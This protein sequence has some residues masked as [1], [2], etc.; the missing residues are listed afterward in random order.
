MKPSPP[1]ILKNRSTLRPSY[2]SALRTP[3]YPHPPSQTLT[4]MAIGAIVQGFTDVADVLIH[5]I[6]VIVSD[7]AKPIHCARCKREFV[8]GFGVTRGLASKMGGA[9]FGALTDERP[10]SAYTLSDAQI[11]CR[12]CYE[13]YL[14]YVNDM[15]GKIDNQDLLPIEMFFEERDL[16]DPLLAEKE[17]QAAKENPGSPGPLIIVART[18]SRN[19]DS[20]KS[21]ATLS[22]SSSR[23][24]S[25]SDEKERSFAKGYSGDRSKKSS[26]APVSFIGQGIVAASAGT[27]LVATTST[28]PNSIPSQYSTPPSQELPNLP[29][30]GAGRRSPSPSFSSS[31][32][33]LFRHQSRSHSRPSSPAPATSTP[34]SRRFPLS[35]G[36]L[37]RLFFASFQPN[38][39]HI[40]AAVIQA[41]RVDFHVAIFNEE[42]PSIASDDG[43]SLMSGTTVRGEAEPDER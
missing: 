17:K 35:V 42:T 39:P 21:T 1:H 32:A 14:D 25:I 36:A 7:P 11:W 23:R 28:T 18:P 40:A 4:L 2:S 5:A 31:V 12:M 13:P 26:M 8:D 33:S 43:A 30:L 24:S 37:R 22:R 34:P 3:K 38:H 6:R 16:I 29:A 15:E 27:V 20:E 19:S 41:S 10:L 9:Y